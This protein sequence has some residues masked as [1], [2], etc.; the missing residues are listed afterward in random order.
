MS[1]RK[2]NGTFFYQF[3][4]FI[5]TNFLMNFLLSIKRMNVSTW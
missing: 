3:I 1:N 2:N 5:F 4:I